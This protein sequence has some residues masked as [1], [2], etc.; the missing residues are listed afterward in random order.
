M[1][2]THWVL[3]YAHHTC[4]KVSIT[5]SYLLSIFNS[6]FQ[7]QPVRAKSNVGFALVRHRRKLTSLKNTLL[8]SYSKGGSYLAYR[9][10]S[11]GALGVLG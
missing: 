11:V 3:F 2:V 7:F 4:N 6:T 1:I 8:G 9:A 5:V 10:M